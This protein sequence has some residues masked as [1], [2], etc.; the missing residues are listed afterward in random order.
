MR[1]NQIKFRTPL[2]PQ[3]RADA[4]TFLHSCNDEDDDSAT[5]VFHEAEWRI[6]GEWHNAGLFAKRGI[7]AE[8]RERR[9]SRIP[10]ECSIVPRIS[11]HAR[12]RLGTGGMNTAVCRGILMM[13][14]VQEIDDLSQ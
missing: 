8:S 7:P 14:A 5:T 12:I 6:P 3:R 1:T 11:E 2:V 13:I 10:D 4:E 9:E